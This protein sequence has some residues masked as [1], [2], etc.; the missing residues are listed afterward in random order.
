EGAAA[1]AGGGAAPEVGAGAQDE[2]DAEG[3]EGQPR[4]RQAAQ[5]DPVLF[6]RHESLRAR[7]DGARGEPVEIPAPIPAMV[8]ERREARKVH[9]EGLERSTEVVGQG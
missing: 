6:R 2:A 5:P 8:G 1:R 7:G 4:R 3:P 9:A